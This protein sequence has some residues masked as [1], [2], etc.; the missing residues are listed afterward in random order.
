MEI[1]DVYK[2]MVN[3][4]PMYVYDGKCDKIPTLWITKSKW[5]YKINVQ[6]VN[7]EM[8]YTD[9]NGDKMIVCVEGEYKYNLYKCY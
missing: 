9:S 6:M 7:D 8:T 3:K 4:T 2:V 1:N 5:D